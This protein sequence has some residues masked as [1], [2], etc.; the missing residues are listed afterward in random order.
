MRLKPEDLID[1]AMSGLLCGCIVVASSFVLNCCSA[2]SGR[3]AA[4]YA[5]EQML[6]IEKAATRE[7]ADRCR[8]AVKAK[9]RDAGHE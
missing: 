4:E 8:D 3:V 5:S 2:P 6:C 1:L 9:Y 7:E